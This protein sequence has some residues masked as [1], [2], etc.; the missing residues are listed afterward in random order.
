MTINVNFFNYCQAQSSSTGVHPTE[1]EVLA[2]MF[3]QD[4]YMTSHHSGL[5]LG[6]LRQCR[7]MG[8][9]ILTA[10]VPV[11]EEEYEQMVWWYNNSVNDY[12]KDFRKPSKNALKISSWEAFTEKQ[13]LPVIDDGIELYLFMDQ[14]EFLKS[15]LAESNFQ[16]PEILEML[17][18]GYENKEIFEKLGVQKS[19]GYKKVNYT[20]KEGIELY[21]ELNK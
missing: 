14:F 8:I 4:Y 3:V 12:L 9:P 11:A 13:D 16:A 17:F 18:K 21:K 7:I 5:L 20:K 1:S 2:P 6:T 10:F 15:K 19:A